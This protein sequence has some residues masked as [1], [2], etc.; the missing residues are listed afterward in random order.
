MTVQ[1]AMHHAL[2]LARRGTGLVSPNPRVGCVI[3]HEGAVLAEGWHARFGQAHAEVMALQQCPHP[4]SD[5][6]LVVT[7]E[8]CSH[9]GK[10]PPCADAII[11]SG[12]RTVVVGMVDPNPAVAGRGIQRLRDA[13]VTVH[14]GVE[15]EHCQWLN[16]WFITSMTQRRA[17]LVTKIAQSLDGA[18]TSASG[19]SQWITSD[20]SR[21]I[22]HELRAECDAIL[23]GIGTAVADNPLLTVRLVEG[24]NPM[25]MVLDPS[26]RLPL[27][28]ALVR[29][30]EDTPVVVWHSPD[31][32]PDHC[33]A[34]TDAGV[35]CM[36]LPLH[37][38]HVQ[39]RQLLESAFVDLGLTSILLEGGPATIAEALRQECVDELHLHV[40]PIML[41]VNN[42]WCPPF[43]GPPMDAPRW[44][45][46]HF[47]TVDG[48]MHVTLVPGVR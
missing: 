33:Q 48:D 20:A 5:A 17:S 23:V 28:S 15:E 41:G 14:V 12:I 25:R 38:G 3:M 36:E 9:V 2:A 27:S 19:S 1:E 11:A 47:A 45:V 8:P 10:T 24:R 30:A 42:A 43:F 31:A 35:H 26:A 13:G 22:V 40:A 34:L 32:S 21:R 4:P 37:N 29:T 44:R 39:I 6:A 46:V 7:L 16:R 18:M